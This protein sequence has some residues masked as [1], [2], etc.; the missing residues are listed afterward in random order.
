LTCKIVNQR[1]AGGVKAKDYNEYLEAIK[2]AH[3]I[4]DAEKRKTTLLELKTRLLADY[5]LN[6]A[7]AK[8]L[9]N[10]C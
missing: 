9:I 3:S 4:R 8:I 7:D 10:K 1:G 6:D 5:G 2:Y